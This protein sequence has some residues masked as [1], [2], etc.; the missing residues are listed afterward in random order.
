MSGGAIQEFGNNALSTTS[1]MQANGTGYS[2][3]TF[4]LAGT[5]I[6]TDAIALTLAVKS[7]PE[8]P[9]PGTV[10]KSPTLRSRVNVV[11]KPVSV[12]KTKTKQACTL[13]LVDADSS[14]GAEY[15]TS[16][17][18]KDISLGRADHY[19]LY[20]VLDS[21]DASANPVLPQVTVTGVSGTFTKGET[22]SGAT[23]GCNA[24]IVNTTNPITYIV[25]NGKEFVT[26]E[27]ITGQT[28]TATATLGTLT[29][30]S[31][32]IT[33]RFTLDTGQR[34]NFYDISRIIRKWKTNSSW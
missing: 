32:D 3:A 13:T 33:S 20:A 27:T 1:Y 21:E 8:P 10:T 34:D 14:A 22:I 28:S 2:F 15:G 29:A 7:L 5:N 31:K 6:Y 9:A 19:K 18:H 4:D 26:N 25:T 17:Q 11:L 16:S 23:S 12:E 24:V 30:G